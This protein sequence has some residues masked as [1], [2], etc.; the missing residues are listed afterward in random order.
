MPSRQGISDRA[1][2]ITQEL[3]E[4]WTGNIRYG[5]AMRRCSYVSSKTDLGE[6]RKLEFVFVTER[7][8]L[9]QLLLLFYFVAV[10][11]LR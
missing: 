6:R 1:L 11:I 3:A 8:P 7:Y 10:Q 9:D 5:M 2:P 4:G